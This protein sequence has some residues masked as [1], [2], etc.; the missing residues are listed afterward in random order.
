M[1]W[2]GASSTALLRRQSLGEL[3]P[4]EAGVET[5]LDDQFVMGAFG[6]SGDAES[7]PSGVLVNESWGSVAASMSVFEPTPAAN[8]RIRELPLCAVGSTGGRNTL[9]GVCIQASHT[10][11][12]AIMTKALNEARVFSHRSAMRR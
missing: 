3:K 4:G 5:A 11:V 7:A 1:T 10:M 2:V 6:Q 9:G 8:P 12:Q